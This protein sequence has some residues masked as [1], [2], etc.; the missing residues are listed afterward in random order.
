[1]LEWLNAEF[2]RARLRVRPHHLEWFDAHGVADAALKAAGGFGVCRVAFSLDGSF[3]PADD[4]GEAAIILP[5]WTPSGEGAPRVLYD[6]VAFRPRGPDFPCWRR[7]LDAVWLGE[8]E[9]EIAAFWHLPLTLRASVMSWLK[10]GARGTVVMDWTRAIPRL[11][12]W[13]EVVAET[14]ALTERLRD[15]LSRE[16]LARLPIIRTEPCPAK[17][18]AEPDIDFNRAA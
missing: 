7:R 16:L 3:E 5:A 12:E 9:L 6:L 10:A 14:D 4:E 2:D 18:D 13:G 1:M 15:V 11:L 8:D 17:A